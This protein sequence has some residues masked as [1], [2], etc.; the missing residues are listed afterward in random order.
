MSNNT[1]SAV[2]SAIKL[3]K[4]HAIKNE[5]ELLKLSVLHL[6]CFDYETEQAKENWLSWLPFWLPGCCVQAD[7]F[8][9]LGIIDGAG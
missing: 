8:L 7:I 9:R 4:C 5:S 2:I 1:D 3:L 6:L